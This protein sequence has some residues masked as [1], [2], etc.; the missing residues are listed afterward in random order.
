MG[1]P[2]S[3][4][5]LDHDFMETQECADDKFIWTYTSPIFPVARENRLQRF[6]LP[7]P[8]VCIGGFLQIELLGRVQ[9]QAADGKYYIC[10]AHVQAIG[11]R[12]SPAFSVEFSEPS[13]SVSLKYD[14]AEFAVAMQNVSSGSNNSLSTSLLPVQPPRQLAWGNLQDFMQMVQAHPDGVEYEWVDDD[15]FEMV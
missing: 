7:E 1:H 10:V 5:E 11:R 9:E 13:N 14:A 12:L 6:K 4:N 3:W 8:V 15:E 2:K